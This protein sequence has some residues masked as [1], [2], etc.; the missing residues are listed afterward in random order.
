MCT[1]VYASHTNKF[2]G[3]GKQLKQK[4]MYVNNK[5]NVYQASAQMQTMQAKGSEKLLAK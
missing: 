5:A 1:L 2:F 3:A 4:H